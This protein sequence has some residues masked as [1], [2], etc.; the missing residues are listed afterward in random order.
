MTGQRCAKIASLLVLFFVVS[1][2][3]SRA[4]NLYIIERDDFYGFSNKSG[5]PIIPPKYGAVKPFSEGLAPVYETGRWGFINSEGKMTIEPDF[6]DAD[7]FSDGLAAIHQKGGWGYIDRTGKVVVQPRYL[8]ARRFSEGVAP[9]KG[10]TGWLFVDNAGRP[11]AGLS[12]FEDAKNFSGGL[13]AVK[14]GGKWRFIT[15][16]GKKK[17]DLEFTKVSSFNE[18]LAAV[19]EE[20]NGKCGFIDRLGHYVIRPVFEDAMP[21]SEGL[22]AV[23]LNKRWGYINKSGNMQIPNDYPVFAD[24]FIGGLSVVSDPV[25]GAELYINADGTPQFFKSRKPADTGRG[26]ADY[27]MCPLKISSTPPKANVYLV[28]AY[29]WDHGDQ[30]QP[31][32]SHLTESQLKDYLK[33]HFN[34]LRGE[35]DFDTRVIEQTYVA[36]FVLGEDMQR[37]WIEIRVG[38]NSTSVSFEHK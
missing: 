3:V 13:A 18:D 31:P 22:A 23:R 1:T 19:Q 32:L 6:W 36:L 27:A 10:E 9:V 24:A 37:R 21:F 29:M 20:E 16:K 4:Q 12:G 33:E 17:F 26:P 34:L 38:D 7:N 11:A 35:T 8:Q 5:K 2:E 30:N 15:H 28:P 25:D 14:G